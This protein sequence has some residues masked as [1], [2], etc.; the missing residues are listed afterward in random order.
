MRRAGKCFEGWK[1]TGGF[2]LVE[3]VV[4][5]GVISIA[6]VSII[7]LLPVA[8]KSNKTSA[9]ETFAVGILTAVEMDLRN[10]AS[11]VSPIYGLASPY[12]RSGQTLAFG[13]HSAGTISTV[14]IALD[15]ALV[16]A[17]KGVRYQASVVYMKVP[18]TDSLKPLEARVIVNWPCLGTVST[19]TD[20]TDLG[21]VSGF[22]ETY[23]TFPAP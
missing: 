19:A 16:P 11:A 7:A 2:S 13:A 18:P 22:L 12:V 5:L 23:V 17:A 3:V 1:G 10:S 15:G 6:L 14:G 21:K 4:A 9:E 20:L 8:V